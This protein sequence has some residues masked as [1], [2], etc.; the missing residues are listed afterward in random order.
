MTSSQTS[1]V[2]RAFKQTARRFLLNSNLTIFVAAITVSAGIFLLPGISGAIQL[3]LALLVM[4]ATLLIVWRKSKFSLVGPLF[5]YDL[6]RLAQRGRTAQVRCLYLF[7][8]IGILAVFSIGPVFEVGSWLLN[9]SFVTRER[10]RAE[11]AHKTIFFVFSLQ[12]GAILILTPGYLGSAF[13]EE[14]ERKTLQFLLTTDLQDHELVLGKLFGRLALLGTIL[15][16]GLPFIS[17]YLAF[18]LVDFSFVAIGIAATVLLLLSAGAISVLS[19]IMCRT[20][21]GSV[22]CSFIVLAGLN[23]FCLAIP[24]TSAL[25]VLDHCEKEVAREWST[26]KME[27]EALQTYRNDSQAIS[28]RQ[29]GRTITLPP[30]II[31]R[32]NLAQIRWEAFAPFAMLHAVIFLFCAG[33]SIGIVRKVCLAPGH[34]S[35]GVVGPPVPVPWPNP[36]EPARIDLVSHFESRSHSAPV[37]DPALLWKET[38]FG[39]GVF[40]LTMLRHL[41]SVASKLNVAFIALLVLICCFFRAWYSQQYF[42]E[43]DNTLSF[44]INIVTTGGLGFWCVLVAL[45]MAGSLTREREQDTLQSLLMLPGERRD[46]LIAKWWGGILRYGGIGSLLFVLWFAGGLLGILHPLS[47]LLLVACGAVYLGFIATLGLWIS[48]ASRST[49]WANMSVILMM[50]LLFSGTVAKQMADTREFRSYRLNWLRE[51]PESLVN[52]GYVLFSAAFSWHQFNTLPVNDFSAD[53]PGSRPITIKP[54]AMEDRDGLMI[55]KDLK[56]SAFHLAFFA[57][58]AGLFWCLTRWQFRR[59]YS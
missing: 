29:F 6:A 35:T 23:V 42:R 8:F 27:I 4:S 41:W 57:L 38:E 28:A 9:E 33:L 49:L 53:G 3:L 34:G 18:D 10:E 16:V 21:L 30:V 31:P 13:T 20:T 58:T 12:I 24:S 44:L 45:R 51:A 47:V 40:S 48:L 22:L 37:Q 55:L 11:L 25:F 26:W 50:M 17:L 15:F 43:F 14:K 5:F 1:A 54:V 46:I 39:D 56:M 32:P 19:S 2:V 36:G 52:P 7:V 59:N